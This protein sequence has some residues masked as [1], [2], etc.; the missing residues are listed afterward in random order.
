M[1]K[2]LTE[3]LLFGGQW[4][5][6][7]VAAFLGVVSPKNAATMGWRMAALVPSLKVEGVTEKGRSRGL[8]KGRTLFLLIACCG[9]VLKKQLLDCQWGATTSSH[10]TP[11]PGT[12]TFGCKEKETTITKEMLAN[13]QGWQMARV[14]FLLA[15]FVFVVLIQKNHKKCLEKSR[16]KILFIAPLRKRTNQHTHLVPPL[17]F[18]WCPWF[19]YCKTI[20]RLA[21]RK[22]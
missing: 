15:R 5:F 2:F 18:G 4:G 6:W 13:L 19:F 17:F 16:K 10:K 22:G 21:Q 7:R 14:G 9:D 12:P 3:K 8:P 11:P 20:C 1:G